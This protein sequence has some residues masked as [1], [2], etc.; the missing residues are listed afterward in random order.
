M[1]DTSIAQRLLEN[2]AAN[3]TPEN[4]NR[5]VEA[6]LHIA[7]IIARKFS[8]RG[9]DYDDLYQVAA[10]ALVKAVERYD[11]GRGVKFQSFATPNMVGEV[12][13]YFRDR[14]RA[15]RL[16]RRGAQ[17]YR[18]I[19]RAREQLVQR[20]R[21]EPRVDE[22]AGALGVSEDSVL[23]ALEIGAVAMVSLD[24]GTEAADAPSLDVFLGIED[25]GFSEFEKNDA[26]RRAMDALEPRR[27]EIIRLRFFENRSQ[28]EVAQRLGVS[29]MT[30][31]R[32]ERRALQ[33]MRGVLEDNG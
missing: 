2:Y 23:E 33:Q 4:R 18:E 14:A 32:E 28:R 20:H 26:V 13:N 16:P 6:H 27:R 19:E 29:Q 3:P 30:V 1:A 7:R 8:G 15:L 25:R 10:M 9:A 17:L 11:P 5:V 21:R 12:K 24:A 31:S 22:L